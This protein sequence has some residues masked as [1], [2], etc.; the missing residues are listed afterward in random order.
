LICV[1][2]SMNAAVTPVRKNDSSSAASRPEINKAIYY[3]CVVDGD[4]SKKTKIIGPIPADFKASLRMEI[5]IFAKPI[6]GYSE[7]TFRKVLVDHIIPMLVRAQ[8]S[9]MQSFSL[10]V[11]RLN[12]FSGIS[13]GKSTLAAPAQIDQAILQTI[14]YVV[15]PLAYCS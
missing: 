8:V 2:R 14:C 15:C 6:D 4:I 10:F 11:N 5:S 13:E 3:R 9:S 1:D 12:T 7:A